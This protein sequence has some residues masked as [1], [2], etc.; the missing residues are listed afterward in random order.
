MCEGG[1]SKGDPGVGDGC[2]GPCPV[3]RYCPSGTWYFNP[4]LVFVIDTV[5]VVR[6]ILINSWCLL[7]AYS[8]EIP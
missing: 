2:G 6:G 7:P 8:V 3:G 4:F 5:R 1:C